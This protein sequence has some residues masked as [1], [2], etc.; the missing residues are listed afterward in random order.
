MKK[1]GGREK[2][3]DDGGVGRVRVYVCVCVCLAGGPFLITLFVYFVPLGLC[4]ILTF[5]T[6]FN[7]RESLI[8]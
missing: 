1:L 5:R 2:G 4:A 6:F 7:G 8:L 3:H